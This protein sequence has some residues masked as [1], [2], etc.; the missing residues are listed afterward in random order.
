M[1][2]IITAEQHTELAKLLLTTVNDVYETLPVEAQA[3]QQ[4]ALQQLWQGI[5]LLAAKSTNDEK[6]LQTASAIIL[7][8]QTAVNEMTAQRD[9][10][11]DDLARLVKAMRHMDLNNPEVQWFWGKVYENAMEN[12]NAAFWESLPYDMANVLGDDWNHMTADKLYMLI[13]EDE[14][15]SEYDP[16][17]LRAWRA[18]LLALVQEFKDEE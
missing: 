3:Q 4:A 1:S 10:I 7:A 2:D 6:A 9:L 18:K 5:E 11:A 15:E 17:Q 8:Q 13:T 12:H 16:E 14:E